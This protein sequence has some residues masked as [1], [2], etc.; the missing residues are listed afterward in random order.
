MIFDGEKWKPV[1]WSAWPTRSATFFKSYPEKEALEGI[2]EHIN[3]FWEP[4]MRR[5]FFTHG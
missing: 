5:M 1:T 2:A 3:K 4:R